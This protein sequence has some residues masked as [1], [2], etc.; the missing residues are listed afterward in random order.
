VRV[1]GDGADPSHDGPRVLCAFGRVDPA[2]RQPVGSERVELVR[3]R[4]KVRL[5]RGKPGMPARRDEA[6]V[7]E[8]APRVLGRMPVQLEQLDA[9]EAE[10]AERSTASK[11]RAHA[12]RRV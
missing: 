10:L 8:P 2:E 4:R 7:V 12:A 5:E 6:D 9:V 11:S 1:L 3:E